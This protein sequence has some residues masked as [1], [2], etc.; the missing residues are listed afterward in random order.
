M[1]DTFRQRYLVF[2]DFWKGS[3]SP[4]FFYTGNEGDI[5]WFYNNTVSVCLCYVHGALIFYASFCFVNHILIAI[6]RFTAVMPFS[7]NDCIFVFQSSATT[8]VSA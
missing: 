1:Q 5:V 3:G 7:E 4:I 8:M 6:I 2:D